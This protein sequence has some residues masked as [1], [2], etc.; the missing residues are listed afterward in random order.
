ME[1]MKEEKQTKKTERVERSYVV[2]DARGANVYGDTKRR[3]IMRVA[4][5]GERFDNC[6][7][8][9]QLIAV[10]DGYVLAGKVTA[11]R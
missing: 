6:H 4:R 5:Y 10:P 1:T 11:V 8:S 3:Q 7:A 9:G 2:S